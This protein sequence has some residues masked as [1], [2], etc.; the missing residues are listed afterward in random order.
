MRMI[1]NKQKSPKLGEK[2]RRK[3]K[4]A[5]EFS[6]VTTTTIIRFAG[7]F[8][9]TESGSDAENMKATRDDLRRSGR[10]NDCGS[11]NSCVFLCRLRT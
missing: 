10:W 11:E 5:N 9:A 6:S 7:V 1:E 4:I 2:Q 3:K 8:I